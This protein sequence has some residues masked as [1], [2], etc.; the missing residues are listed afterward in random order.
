M[1]QPRTYRKWVQTQ[2]LVLFKV[3]HRETDLYI[4]ASK[5]LKT[6]TLRLL[7]DIR[8]SLDKYIE[9]HGDFLSSL[10]PLKVADGAP[11]IVKEMERA[12]AKAGVGPMAAVAGAIAE[13][14]GR[15]LSAFS[16]EVIIE[17]GGDI[18]IK[19]Q[20]KRK[21]AIYAGKSPL[22]QKIALT[23]KAEDT[24]LGICTSS[25]T[26]GHSLSMGRADAAVVVSKSVALADAVATAMGNIV[27]KAGDIQEGLDYA[28]NI[29][30]VLGAVV[31]KGDKMGIK[32]EIEI[33]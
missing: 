23:V 31:I 6:E 15:G 17:N 4:A 18:Y 29:S 32:G 1:Y 9:N 7:V 28:C 27:K 33:A 12:A 5:N 22:S 11:V 25:G 3:I 19:S 20:R 21:V 16:D 8:T 24:P 10:K 14:I 13:H 30:G 26:V 2:D